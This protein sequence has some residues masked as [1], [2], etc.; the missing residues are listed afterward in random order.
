MEILIGLA[1]AGLTAWLMRHVLRAPDGQAPRMA[2]IATWLAQVAFCGLYT[3]DWGYRFD[4][5]SPLALIAAGQIEL[6]VPLLPAAVIALTLP[7]QR[8]RGAL[9][10]FS[11]SAVQLL[12][13]IP[14]LL[15]LE[16]RTD[17]SF[18]SAGTL[19]ALALSITATVTSLCA[20][21]VYGARHEGRLRTIA[22][23]DRRG[24]LDYLEDAA[25]R[26]Q[27]ARLGPPRT[28]LDAGALEGQIDGRDVSIDTRPSS[29]PIGYGLEARLRVAG[30]GPAW[31]L[32]RADGVRGQGLTGPLRELPVAIFDDG[33][34]AP[35]A[36]Y[37]ERDGAA[38]D[39]SDETRLV[40]ALRTALPAL[41]HA[42]LRWQDGE[43]RYRQISAR[44]IEFGLPQERALLALGETLDPRHVQEVG[45]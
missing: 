19:G 14:V 26:W 22:F 30:S 37:R 40:D 5:G 15:I 11:L 29:R 43:L 33:V 20:L 3:V 1:A 27:V 45:A 17:A 31:L 18:L 9:G 2:L 42:T 4:V 38:G 6:L 36:L 10:A 8:A 24:V 41:R 7:V 16:D 21:L 13:L 12:A 34:A 23:Q 39:A 25:A 28:L 35:A 32:T 44:G